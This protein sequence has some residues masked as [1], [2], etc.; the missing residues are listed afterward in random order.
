[1]RC[2]RLSDR[3]LIY[4]LLA[5]VIGWGLANDWML[6]EEWEHRRPTVHGRP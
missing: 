6:G 5:L 4:V 2:T 3:I 1:M